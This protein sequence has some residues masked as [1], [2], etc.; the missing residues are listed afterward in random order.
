MKSLRNKTLDFSA[1]EGK[2]YLEKCIRPDG[3]VIQAELQNKVILGDTF[4]VLPYLP[5]SFVDLL[6][7]DP[8]IG[9][10]HV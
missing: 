8:Q 2:R 9:R 4:Q 10:A 3:P 1:E 7:V 5:H 6:V